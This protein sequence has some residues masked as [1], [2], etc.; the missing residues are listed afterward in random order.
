MKLAEVFSSIQGEG[1]WV[2]VRQ[3]FVRFPKCN[4]VCN[5]C[6]EDDLP[7]TEWNVDQV[8][9]QVSEYLKMVPHH[10]LSFTGGEPTLYAQHILTLAPLLPIP[11]FLETNG[12]LPQKIATLIPHLSYVSLD[13][14]PGHEKTFGESLQL[15]KTLDTYVKW[16]ICA[17]SSE[18]ELQHLTEIIKREAPAIPVFFQPVSP[19]KDVTETVSVQRLMGLVDR[20]LNAGLR[21]RVVPQTH[22]QLG[23]P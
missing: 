9:A 4:I 16:I 19:C 23:L 14:K 12:T 20:G 11:K 3:I 2:G 17:D 8:V 18:T 21:V 15:T 5:Y 10:S 22:K 6:D 13:Y 7:S 1:L